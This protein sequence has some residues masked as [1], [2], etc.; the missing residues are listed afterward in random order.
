MSWYA[1]VVFYLGI[2]DAGLVMVGGLFLAVLILTGR[3]W[4]PLFERVGP[5]LGVLIGSNIT[6]ALILGATKWLMG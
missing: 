3:D 1:T 6:A 2:L 4:R 5:A